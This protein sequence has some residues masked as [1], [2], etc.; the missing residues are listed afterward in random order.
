MSNKH[1]L[2]I[3]FYKSLKMPVSNAYRY[4]ANQSNHILKVKAAVLRR[5]FYFPES[6]GAL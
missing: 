4:V 3:T 6:E 5:R 2:D 1:S